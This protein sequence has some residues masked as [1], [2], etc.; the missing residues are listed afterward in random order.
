MALRNHL[1]QIIDDDRGSQRILRTVLEAD[2]FSVVTS[3]TCAGG[4]LEATSRPPDVMIVRMGVPDRDRI[5]LIKA[6]RTW[7]LMP[8]LAL[9]AGCAEARRLAAF[10]AGADD[11]ILTPFSA[12][13]LVARVRAALRFHARGGLL[14]TGVLELDNISIDLGR[15]IVRRGDR[16][17]QELT[18]LEYRLLEALVRGRNQVVTQAKIMKEV[19]GPNSVRSL[20]LRACV[21]S[22]RQKLEANP[23]HPSRIINEFGV[24]YRLV[25]WAA[26]QQCA[27]IGRSRC[28]ID[29]PAQRRQEY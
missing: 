7:S 1:V 4:E 5:R 13:E 10:D 28:R 15:R 6:I 2:G 22:L 26:P 12:P 9:S 24:G 27:R 29:A 17:G 11:Y 3:D 18:R 21:S 14:P 16:H 25:M 20:E 8:I 23:S 19:W